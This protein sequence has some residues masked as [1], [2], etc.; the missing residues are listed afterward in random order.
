MAHQEQLII[1]QVAMMKLRFE[2]ETLHYRP[3]LY[4][5][6]NKIESNAHSAIKEKNQ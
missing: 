4:D 5:V 6:Q 2:I 3:T 1:I